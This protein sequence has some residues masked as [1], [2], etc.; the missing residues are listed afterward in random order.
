MVSL[1]HRKLP[2]LE[3]V[4]VRNKRRTRFG[5]LFAPPRATPSTTPL[6]LYSATHPAM[7]T[8]YSLYLYAHSG[9]HAD[10][11][12]KPVFQEVDRVE[13]LLSN[14]Q[15]GSEL[16]RINREAFQHHVTT[17]PETFR[18]LETCLAWS[19]RSQ[20][21]FDISV[22]KLMKVWKFFGASGAIPTPEELAAA[23]EDVG[24]KKIKLDRTARTVRFLAAEIELDPGGVGKGY[25]VDRA[26]GVLRARQV[27]AALLSAGS[28]TIYALG[29]PPGEPGWKVRVPSARKG[30]D[31]VSTVILQDTSLSTANLSEKNFVHEGHL[32]GAIMDPRTLRPVEGML[33]VTVISPSATDSDVLSN[34]LF[35][36]GPED[37]AA[38]LEG[39]QQA[40][41]LVILENQLAAEYEATRWPAEVAN[42][43][44]AELADAEE[45]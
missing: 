22:G 19:E 18:F 8:E 11:I 35:V 15:P 41:A 37:R 20:G 44:L 29:A 25:A 21:A 5:G 1:N 26:V 27:G 12:A 42:G 31:T 40:C 24:W 10:S 30:E 45:R 16:S 43:H 32:Y 33:Q 3:Y 7:G 39:R 6:Q 28:S 2:D 13:G 17:D 38:L 4:D 14:Y 34:A 36:S 23:R 9:A